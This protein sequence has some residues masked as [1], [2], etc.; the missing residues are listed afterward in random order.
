MCRQ[1]EGA[2]MYAIMN[3]EMIEGNALYLWFSNLIPFTILHRA[4]SSFYKL[5]SLKQKCHYKNV[6]KSSELLPKDDL[7]SSKY[8]K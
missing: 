6:N 8:G 5:V 3:P 4:F 2:W 1:S 7:Q